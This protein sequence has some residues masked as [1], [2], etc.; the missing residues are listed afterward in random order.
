MRQPWGSVEKWGPCVVAV[1]ALFA[2]IG[3]GWTTSSRMSKIEGHTY[4]HSTAHDGMEIALRAEIQ[5]WQ[6]YVVSLQAIMIKNGIK[7]VPLPPKPLSPLSS[8]SSC[9]SNCPP[10]K[11][12]EK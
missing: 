5:T 1:I 12:K 4:A 6:A 2:V 9:P 10:T 7:D 11:K 8:P 3:I